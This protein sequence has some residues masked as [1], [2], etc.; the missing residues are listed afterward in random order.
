MARDQLYNLAAT[1]KLPQGNLKLRLQNDWLTVPEGY[2]E[3]GEDTYPLPIRIMEIGSFKVGANNDSSE[4]IYSA[5]SIDV[6]I[7][8]EE[9][10]YIEWFNLM[11]ELKNTQQRLSIITAV[12]FTCVLELNG[13][14]IWSGVLMPQNISGKLRNREI[15]LTFVDYMSRLK[16]ADPRENP[17]SLNLSEKYLVTDIIYQLLNMFNF[18]G[19]PDVCT[20]VV[21]LSNYEA[22]ADGVEATRGFEHF[23]IFASNY[24]RS[25]DLYTDC[26]QV[27]KSLLASFGCIGLLGLDRIF[28]IIPRRYSGQQKINLLKEKRKDDDIQGEVILAKKGLKVNVYTGSPGVFQTYNYGNVSSDG[29]EEITIHEPAGLLPSGTVSYSGLSIWVDTQWYFVQMNR[30]RDKNPD[31]SYTGYKSNW[32]LTADAYWELINHH[33]SNLIIP[34]LSNPVAFGYSQLLQDHRI[35]L[36]YTMAEFPNII[37][38]PRLIDYNLLED[39][40]ELDLIS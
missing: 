2:T 24:F 28:Y 32:R 12:D 16:I 22:E 33:R 25:D 9:R 31:G 26:S 38:R 1:I 3:R 34:V 36:Y 14:P 29:I 17:L 27:L 10:N 11:K 4:L 19:V 7:R 6:K 8:I 15:D 20:Q 37:F 23:G 21:S 40:A 30:V 13:S 39:E 5:S 35:G 18:V